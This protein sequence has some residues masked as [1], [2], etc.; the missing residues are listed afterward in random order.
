VSERPRT[1]PTAI[2][3]DEELC[4][5]LAC[6]DLV[7]ALPARWVDRLVLPAEVASVATSA[8]AA[9]ALVLAGERQLAA[10]NLG[11]LLGLPPLG[12][13]WVLLRIPFRGSELPIALHTGACLVVQPLPPALALPPGAFRAR[14]HA[15]S[16]AFASTRVRGRAPASPVGLWIDPS[17]LFTDDELAAAASALG[18]SASG[19]T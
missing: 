8:D 17:R 7:C 16:G 2:R 14:P 13:A 5:V 18:A 4:V 19:A 9:V 10:W 3:R 6:H 11:T 12:T 1:R 15:I